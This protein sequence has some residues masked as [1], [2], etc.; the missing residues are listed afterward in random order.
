MS[1][2]YTPKEPEKNG[3]LYPFLGDG[4][5]KGILITLIP[6]LITCII[7]RAPQYKMSK[8]LGTELPISFDAISLILVSPYYF[9][10]M[11][12]LLLG[13]A[14][15]ASINNMWHKSDIKIIK[16]LTILLGLSAI[17]ILFQFFLVLA[18]NGMCD[19]R[20]YWELLWSIQAPSQPVSHCM[21]TAKD[22]NVN[23]WLYL[24]PV[25]LQAWMHILLTIGSLYYLYSAWRVWVSKH[26][27][28][29]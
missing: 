3:L 24:E 23:A 17:F 18:P 28:I 9:L 4:Y 29:H 20:P 13:T 8:I 2:S 1:N 19:Q 7:T 12:I 16:G 26:P 25:F 22:I 10:V 11:T 6:S 21:S 15:R 27:E 14:R 5:A